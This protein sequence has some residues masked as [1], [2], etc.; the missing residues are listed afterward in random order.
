[1]VWL[2]PAALAG[3]V[4]VLGPL[5]VHLL[6]RQRAR[7]LVVPTVRFIPAVD[8]SVVRV[9]MPTDVT[10]LA[11][12]MAIVACAA[13]AL[14]RPLF[15]TDSREKAWAER[16]ARV[17][18]V[19]VSSPALAAQANEAALAEL[20]SAAFTQRIDAA[21]LGPA[22]QRASDWLM[23]APPARRELVVIS[24]FQLGTIDEAGVGKIPDAIGLRL[25]P[26]RGAS[27]TSREI[28]SGTVLGAGTTFERRAGIDATSTSS[29]FLRQAAT[30]DGLR[31]LAAADD[32]KDVATLLRV[33]SRAG[34]T[35]PS[36]AEPIVVR[37]AGGEALP[38]SGQPT[39]QG[40]AVAAALRLL[41][42]SDRAG[43]PVAASIAQDG[44]LL[45]DVDARPGTLLA[46][47]SL[48]AALDARHD[49]Q[50]LAAQEIAHI[51]TA[52]LDAWGR[53]PAPA[54]TTAWPRADESDGRWFWLAA[55]GLL[56]LEGWI[57]RARASAAPVR[58][59]D[60]H[61]A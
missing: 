41:T 55:L 39:A 49:P 19:H 29:T 8:Q 57:C 37:F 9:R 10:L 61:A 48:Q 3:L 33:V 54:D 24:D 43:Y 1:M 30:L 4:A 45:V 15:L 47:A 14:A 23:G 7:T 26:V 20:Q 56:A 12:R 60:A 53:A 52:R 13:L 36:A 58:E 51:P 28:A 22:L 31:V 18:V 38:P 2:A 32:A 11:V 34:A 5:I 25:V 44:A 16:V 6:R 21:E 35:A 59:V 42:H 46:A 27:E 50:R 17:T 40:W